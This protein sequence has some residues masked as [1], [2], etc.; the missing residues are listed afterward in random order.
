MR[1]LTGNVEEPLRY[2]RHSYSKKS[3]S[4]TFQ[5]RWQPS[6]SS[7]LLAIARPSLYRLQFINTGNVHLPQ[8][9]FQLVF[10]IGPLLLIKLIC[11]PFHVLC[12]PV[13]VLS[14]P[15][16][17]YSYVIPLLLLYSFYINVLLSSPSLVPSGN[18]CLL[19]HLLL[20]YAVLCPFLL[21]S[22]LRLF[23]Y[24]PLLLLYAV[25]FSASLLLIYTTFLLFYSSD[26]YSPF[27]SSIFTVP[28]ACFLKLIFSLVYNYI[29]SFGT[30]YP[31]FIFH[32]S[33]GTVWHPPLFHLPGLRKSSKFPGFLQYPRLC[34]PK[35]GLS[36]E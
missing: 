34:Q 17:L 21:F 26:T 33:E 8:D 5:A 35:R 24:S 4:E 30:V 11:S 31:S 13:L 18:L 12:D 19:L 14:F 10:E 36:I 9:L 25:F 27:F 20:F 29:F 22:L 3:P 32:P 15:C 7:H 6:F 16:V 1:F 28:I 23:S 2:L